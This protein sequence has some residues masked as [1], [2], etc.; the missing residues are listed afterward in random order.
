MMKVLGLGLLIGLLSGLPA[1]AGPVVA[2]I[3]L[4][5][6]TMRVSVDG[7]QKYVW[8]VSTGK[9]GY[10]TPTG[11]FRPYRLA[12][13]YYSKKYDNAPMPHSVFFLGGYAIH[14]T[15]KTGSLGSAVS[16]GC[17]RLAPGNAATLYSL[18]QKHGLGSA[19]VV[20]TN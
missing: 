8:R 14:G 5:Q 16:H 1:L 3:D 2:K 20:V 11:T 4:S 15:N 9:P 18:V 7:A 13:T 19:R 6:Q 10:R 17:V 12:R